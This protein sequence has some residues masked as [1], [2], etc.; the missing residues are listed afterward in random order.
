MVKVFESFEDETEDDELMDSEK[1]KGVLKN[2]DDRK[3]R[4][5]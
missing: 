3:D 2:L 4:N 5:L 1:V